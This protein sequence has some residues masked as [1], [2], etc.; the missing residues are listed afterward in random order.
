MN[1]KCLFINFYSHQELCPKPIPVCQYSGQVQSRAFSK[2]TSPP[3]SHRKLRMR[4]IVLLTFDSLRADHCGFMGYDRDTTPT[5]DALAEDGVYYENAV[6]PASRTPYA[7]SGMFSGEPLTIRDEVSNPEHTNRHLDRHGS[8]VEDLS[9]QGYATGAF[10][11]NAYA[12]RTYGFNRG[13]DLF[14]DFLF[15]SSFYQ[16][17]FNKHIKDTSASGLVTNIRNIR[18]FIRREEVF[19]TWDRYVDDIIDWVHDQESPFFLWTF[20]LETHFPYIVPRAYRQWGGFFKMYYYNF[21]GNQLIDELDVD[22]SEEAVQALIDIYD[23]TIYFAD[24]LVD[25]LRTE[26]RDFDPVFIVTGDHGEAFFEHGPYGHFYPSM[27]EENI[28]V[29]LVVWN[30]N[31]DPDAVS[32]PVSLTDMPEFLT[33]ADDGAYVPSERDAIVSTEYDGRWNRNIFMTRS[34]DAKVILKETDEGL[35]EEAYDLVADP[36]EQSPLDPDQYPELRDKVLRRY[37]QEREQLRICDA[38]RSVTQTST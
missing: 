21:K 7:V 14:E 25:R 26:L 29:P 32:T 1:H 9:S 18:N 30:T 27:Y 37:L 34:E 28:H 36:T 22:I 33:G 35:T 15:E 31:D 38:T 12:S 6:S 10:C 8:V 5:I 20:G 23:D 24:A 3:H 2:D 11:P 16:T 13:F 17:V 4:N 19:R